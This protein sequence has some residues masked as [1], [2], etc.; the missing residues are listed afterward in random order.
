MLSAIFAYNLLAVY[1][2]QVTPQSGWTQPSTLCA[3]V[4]VCGAVLGRIGRKNVLRVSQTR[5]GLV[6]HQALIDKA[7]EP[8]GSIAPLLARDRPTPDWDTVAPGGGAI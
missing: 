4:F 2:A 7:C 1:Q 6:K 5:G 8:P 3:A